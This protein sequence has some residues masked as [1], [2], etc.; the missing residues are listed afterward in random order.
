MK[1]GFQILD[2]DLHVIEPHDLYLK[3]MDP[4]WGDRIP[5]AE[6]R[7]LGVGELHDFTTADGNL[8]RKPWREAPPKKAMTATSRRIH[9]RKS[10]IAPDYTEAVERQFDPVSQ[11]KAMD[12]EGIDVAVLFRTFPLHADESQEPE[13]ANALCRAWNDWIT[14]FCKENPKRMKAAGLITLHDV[15]LAMAEAQRVVKELGHVG[16]CMIPQPVNNRHVHD[17]Y[18]D[19]LWAAIEELGV[20]VC[21]HPTAGNN[22][23]CA[24]N[25]FMGHRSASLLM[26]TFAQPLGNV[27]GLAE[28]VLGGILERHP[29]L[30]VG[31]LEGN[32]SWLP[33]L[34]YRLD[35]R[36]EIFGADAEV[37]LSCKPSEYFQ[38]QCFAHI[39]VE[40]YTASD[41]LRRFG[42][43]NFFFSTDYPHADCSFPHAT[44][45][46]LAL[47]GIDAAAK[48]K[49]LWDN[50]AR[51]YNL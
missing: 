10:Q 37:Q 47:E 17:D 15:D 23:P 46:F 11:I 38:R 12:R 18:F 51:M 30:S 19:P 29:R 43:D 4:K 22:Q 28:F 26:S 5:R 3:H 27:M 49:I 32:C 16:L 14:D 24:E 42:P 34:L 35:E 2:A 7:A 13:Y 48:R 9:Q 40:E 6:P 41:V 21:F 1:H 20:P 50:P 8:V 25:V 44:E 36:W 45:K 39:D 33:W 31:F